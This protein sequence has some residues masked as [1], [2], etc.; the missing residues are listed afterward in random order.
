MKLSSKILAIWLLIVL[1]N[2]LSLFL[3]P[4]WSP[5]TL[6][7]FVPVANYSLQSFIF[8][9]SLNIFF[10]EP[11][12]KNK[13]LFLNFAL[14]FSI[15]FLAHLYNFV[16]TLI[17][18]AW[19]FPDPR[20]ARMILDQY[21]FHGAYFFLLSLSIVYVAIDLLMRDMSTIKKYF[22]SIVIVAG[23]FVYYYQPILNDPLF[24][25][26][27]VDVRDWKTLANSSG[28][29]HERFGV[30]PTAEVLAD[31]IEMYSWKD[32]EQTGILFPGAKLKRVLELYPYLSG[33]NYVLLVYRPLFMNSIHMCV[34]CVA[35]ILLF[36]GYQYLK[37]P[38]QG[39]YIEK[40]MFLFLVFC[41]VEILHAWSFVKSIEWQRYIE[42]E[43]IGQG[44]TMT[45]LLLIVLFFSLRLRFITSVKGEFYEQ[46][47]AAGPGRI[48]RWRDTLDNLVI[49]KFFNRKLILGR[50]L[51]DPR[52]KR[53]PVEG[54]SNI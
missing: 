16:G 2:C 10:R 27:T 12:K 19:I 11:V 18:E 15:S 47:L 32:G 29:Y 48:T 22:F 8:L 35:F 44:V 17:T 20:F 49:E 6:G 41:S 42:F 24:L 5:L 7:D 50:M 25:H 54:I 38:P 34:L 21:V 1:V 51:V 45:V 37:D 14:F 23:F 4:P 28:D 52:R 30:E 46:E 39:A 31:Q 3:F 40:I 9:V 53:S 43:V 36:F 33:K 26:H 13:F